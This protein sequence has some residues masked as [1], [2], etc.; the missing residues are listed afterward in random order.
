MLWVRQS[1]QFL[2]PPPAV[3]SMLYITSGN[4]LIYDFWTP[5]GIFLVYDF[6]TPPPIN[7]VHGSDRKCLNLS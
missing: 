2:D 4:F 3:L 6:W 5:F 1:K 7:F